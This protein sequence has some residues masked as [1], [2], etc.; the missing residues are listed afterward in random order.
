MTEVLAGPAWPPRSDVDDYAASRPELAATGRSTRR[1]VGDSRRGRRAARQVAHGP[2]RA[3]ADQ[4]A[5]SPERRP[6]P[7]WAALDRVRRRRSAPGRAAQ[8][9]APGRPLTRSTRPSRSTRARTTGPWRAG[10]NHQRHWQRTC[11]ARGGV[12]AQGGPV[13]ALQGGLAARAGRRLTVA[14]GQSS[15]RRLPASSQPRNASRLRVDSPRDSAPL[16][17]LADRRAEAQL[18]DGVERLV[19]VR[20][21]RPEQ[22]VQ[23]VGGDGRERQ[24]RVEVD[25]AERVDAEGD[26]VHPEV[27]LE[28]PPV[29]ALEVLVGAA[30]DERVDAQ[31]V[32]ADVEPD[33]VSACARRA[34]AARRRPR[35]PPRGR[36]PRRRGGRGRPGWPVRAPVRDRSRARGSLPLD[37]RP[38]RPRPP[39]LP[40]VSLLAH[41]ATAMVDCACR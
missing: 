10:S 19:G 30:A 22:P 31:R 40:G 28:Q 7:G 12:V 5:S 9:R 3:T 14:A 34:A 24:P 23:L 37:R 18:Q 29:D 17:L 27:A 2:K 39:H 4:V 41:E 20:Q 35:R 16:P 8:R 1:A 6:C 38:H 11:G 33:A 21:H 36:S 25:V 13:R 15:D 32:R 26:G